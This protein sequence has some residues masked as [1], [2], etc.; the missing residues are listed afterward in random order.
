[1]AKSFVL[2]EDLPLG[3]LQLACEEIYCR[4]AWMLRALFT[5]PNV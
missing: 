1:M 2:E 4:H 3:D 5:N